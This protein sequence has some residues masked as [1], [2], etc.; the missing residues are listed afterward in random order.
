MLN[1]YIS[2][3]RDKVLFS[4]LLCVFLITIFYWD[5]LAF[6]WQTPVP[7]VTG[8]C[9]IQLTYR[10]TDHQRLTRSSCQLSCLTH[11]LGTKE[12]FKLLKISFL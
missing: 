8:T 6:A 9:E 11:L 5:T 10:E 2:V 7:L 12:S 1:N 4:S 3:A